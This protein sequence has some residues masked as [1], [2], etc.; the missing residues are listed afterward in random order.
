MA[1]VIQ[2]LLTLYQ[3]DLTPLG[4]YL[5]LSRDPWMLLVIERVGPHQLS[6]AHYYEQ[7]GDLI[8]DPEI[9]VFDGEDSIW[10]P[11]Y[12]QLAIGTFTRCATVG[13]GKLG[14]VFTRQAAEVVGLADLWAANLRAQGWLTT[15]G[16]T[17]TKP[18]PEPTPTHDPY[19]CVNCGDPLTFGEGELCGTCWLDS[20]IPTD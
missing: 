17:A 12:C 6:V 20:M 11:L 18:A 16:T 19:H 15:E 4:G 3:A 5:R 14:Q 7:A 10:V 13:A 8:P 1:A 2:D 9:V